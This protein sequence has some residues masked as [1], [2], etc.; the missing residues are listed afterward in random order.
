MLIANAIPAVNCFTIHPTIFQFANVQVLFCTKKLMNRILLVLNIVLVVAVAVLFYLYFSSKP[1]SNK[2][3]APAKVA[4]TTGVNSAFKIA[5]FE[6]DSV[7]NSFAMVKDVKSEL[8]REEEKMGAEMR[9]WQK[10]YNDKLAYY[11][12]QAQAQQMSE[13]QSENAN[14]EMLQL[15]ETI[16]NKKA[17]LDQS[18]QNIYMQ[19]QQAIKLKIE[20][21]L[22]EYNKDKGF[23]YIFANEAGFM[24]LRD[25]AY[26]ITS[27]VVKG[28]NS[29]YKKKEPKK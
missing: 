10:R 13:V 28:L 1:A 9:M 27:D 17:E 15:Q 18:Y 21:F 6:L 3:A 5:Y 23:S 20:E 16:R 2:P 7:T 14:R 25:S 26:D 24:Y 19:K 11:Q 8:S 12:N 22:K 4:G 29:G